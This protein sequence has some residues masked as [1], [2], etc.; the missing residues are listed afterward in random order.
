MSVSREARVK[1]EA[2]AKVN[3]LPNLTDEQRAK[4][5]EI[6][7]AFAIKTHYDPKDDPQPKNTSS[8][9]PNYEGIANLVRSQS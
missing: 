5:L 2:T 8:P 7:E 9:A 4:V 1:E 6:A 3:A